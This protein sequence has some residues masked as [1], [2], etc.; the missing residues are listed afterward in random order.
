MLQEQRLGNDSTDAAGAEQL[1]GGHQQVDNEYQEFAHAPRLH[2][3][4]RAQN[5][6]VLEDFLILGIC[7]PQLLGMPPL[8]SM[9]AK[10]HHYMGRTREAVP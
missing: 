9:L 2:G 4:E 7:H 10:L 1:C 5:C 6:T 3:C 8:I